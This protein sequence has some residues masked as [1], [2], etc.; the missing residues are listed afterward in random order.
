MADEDRE[1]P[2][3]VPEGSGIPPPEELPV[4]LDVSPTED[5]AIDLPSPIEADTDEHSILPFLTVGIGASAGGLEAY[6]ELLAALPPTT[7]MAYILVPHL[8]ADCESYLTQILSRH[9]RMPVEEIRS[10]IPPEPNRVYILPPGMHV[11]MQGGMLHLERRSIDGRPRMPIDRFFRSL[12]ADQK[13]RAIGVVLSGADSDGALGLNAIKGEGGIS[14]VQDPATAKFEEMPR[15]GI[16]ADH[17]D[18][19]LAPGQIAFELARLALEFQRPRLRPL[20]DGRPADGDEKHFA[21]TLHLLRS[22]SGV[23]FTLYKPSTARRRT[24]R[25]MM[26]SQIENLADYVRHLKTHPEE[27]R[28]LHEDLLINVTRF[29][30]DPDVFDVLK[31]EIFPRIF[32]NRPSDQQVRIWVAGCSTGEETYSIAICLLEYLAALPVEPPIQIF[33]TDASD[34]SV[35]KARAGYYPETITADISPDRLR[36]FFV[37]NGHGYQVSKRLRDLCI[38]ARQNVC[39]DPPFSRLDLI[40][41]RNVLIYLT[42]SAQQRI[43][44]TFHYALRPNGHLLLGSSESIREH[45]A[46]Y[47]P[48]D[49]RHKY[50]V[51][52]PGSLSLFPDQMPRISAMELR[53]FGAPAIRDGNN[54]PDLQRATDRVVIARYGPPGVVVNEHMEVLNVRGHTAPY[55]EMAPGPSSLHLMRM[56]REGLGL[57][58]RDALLRA[59]QTDVPVIL[60][61]IPFRHDGET[62]E[63]TLNILPIHGVSGGTRHYLVAFLPPHLKTIVAEEPRMLESGSS[64]GTS[65][66][67]QETVQLR[68]E[69]A[70]SR[71]YLQSL[72]E[73]RDARNQEL[74]SAYEELQSSNEELQSSIEELE[75]AKEELQSTNEEL[76]TVNE[77]L[78]NQNIALL[79]ATN[80]LANL[81]NSVNIPVVMLGSDLTIRQY[82][83]PAERLMQIRPADIGRPISEMRLNLSLDEFEPVLRDVL[84]TLTTKEIEV[85]DRKGR[86]QLLRIRPYRTAE[87]KIDGLVLV[88]VDIDQIRRGEEAMREARDFF[89]SIVES[90]EIPLV[91]LDDELHIGSVNAAFRALAGLRAEELKER[92]FGDLAAML[93]NLPDFVKRV[94]P[95]RENH[96][97]LEF[98]YETPGARVLRFNARP[99]QGQ[100]SGWL[101]L[102]IEDITERRRVERALQLERERLSDEVETTTQQLDRTKSELRS[103]TGSLFSS[104]EDER[105]WVS[106]ELH[107]DIVQRLAMLEV[108][109]ERLELEPLG[110]PADVQ[111]RLRG[112]KERVTSVT[113]DLRTI[114]HRLHPSMLDELGPS[115]ALKALV[116]EFGQRE[117]M[118]VTFTHRR[119]P[120][121]ISH[122]IAGTLYR[123]AQEALRNIAKHAGKTHVKVALEGTKSGL[124][125][126]VRDFGEGFD[127][128]LN[129]QRGLGIISMQERAG[130]LGGTFTIESHPGEGTKVAVVMPLAAAPEE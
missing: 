50:Y 92:S 15:S 121:N 48:L 47:T 82:T 7:G 64:D 10:G 65:A 95:V 55:L 9:T 108:D 89:N 37:R 97:K 112:L 80:D 34:R 32:E 71:L 63:V 53:G 4:E 66:L 42:A 18:M 87:N 60:E 78:R 30:R 38:F 11:I 79:H 125:L 45:G 122:G 35:E 129:G 115:A 31:M 51:K 73:E 116:Q 126:T 29:F 84:D 103:L 19:V 43:V 2:A 85:R 110:Q 109:I 68:Y 59:I 3:E 70:S 69:L 102:I 41:C 24:A 56:A 118:L 81:L 54:E 1:T 46:L 91:V 12:A 77:E 23:D 105:R 130:L 13:N 96:S 117:G 100:G 72:I 16:S 93:W 120:Q 14:I 98:E 88:L 124:R 127:A 49:P 67:S 36:R 39:V 61:D 75:T 119:V 27:L 101:L 8:S 40:S 94:Q 83:P 6:M 57:P 76:H 90:V 25:R 99:V 74:S 5:F 123:I 22:V 26:L 113:E 106:R 111:Q 114:S 62:L 58:L 33:G 20:E 17:V 86:W 104:Q 44:S 128:A 21:H 107:D 52:V 28:A